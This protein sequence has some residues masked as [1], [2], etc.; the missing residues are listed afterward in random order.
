[1]R[2]IILASR[3]T[4]RREI[5]KQIGLKVTAVASDVKEKRMTAQNC[6][7]LV[8]SNALA[9]AQDVAK[10][11]KSGI[12]IG[13][14]TV[15][16]AGKR[17]IGKP[18]NMA[19]AL[20]TLRFLTRVPQLV[21]TGIAVVDI[22]NQKIY[23]D[24]GKTKV[25]MRRMTDSQIKSYF[26][27]VSPLDKAGSY[28]IRGPGAVFVDRIEGCYYNV[29]GLPIAKLMVILEK[30]KQPRNYRDSVATTQD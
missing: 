20:E 4:T 26:R 2:Q 9:K 29:V 28:D 19:D 12:V 27:Q 11:F 17:V 6:R 22:D 23:K 1:M 24:Y 30:I 10:R 8:I 16:V 18:K 13:A 14:D 15:V 5:L 21:Y 25:Y 3:S 7:R